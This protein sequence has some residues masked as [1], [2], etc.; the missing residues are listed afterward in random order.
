MPLTGYTRPAVRA[1]APVDADGRP[2]PYGERW[3]DGP[4]AEA[5]GVD[6]HP[7]RFAPLHEVADALV[8]HLG[9][10][11]AVDVTDD[12]GCADDLGFTVAEPVRAV[13]LAPRR[14]TSATLTVVWTAYPGVVLHAGLLQDFPFPVCG[15]DACDESWSGVADDLEWHVAAVVGGGYREWVTRSGTGHALRAGDR[16][17]SGGGAA[18]DRAGRR[19]VREARRLLGAVPDGWA[20]WPLR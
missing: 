20:A 4:P 10:R 14:S 1:P 3:P 2:V 16:S 6:S 7:G 12:P 19:R 8:R 13:R 9:A 5:Y 11:Y 18:P 15:C 17:T